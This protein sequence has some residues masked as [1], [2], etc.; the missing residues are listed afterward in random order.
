LKAADLSLA[1][2][3]PAE[4]AVVL[5]PRDDCEVYQATLRPLV[6]AWCATIGTDG[7][8]GQQGARWLAA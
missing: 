4:Q 7:E 3:I 6:W 1:P 8:A 5:A 2:L